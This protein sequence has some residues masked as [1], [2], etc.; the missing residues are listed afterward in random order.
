MKQKEEVN[1][2]QLSLDTL[3]FLC[4]ILAKVNLSAADANFTEIAA[5]VTKARNELLATVEAHPDVNLQSKEI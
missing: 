1:A 2:P 5:K 4:E 3:N